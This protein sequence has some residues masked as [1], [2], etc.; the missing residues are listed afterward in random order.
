MS[1]LTSEER[2]RLPDEAFAYIDR[3][4]ERHLP[5]HDAAHVRNA[6]A[7]YPQTHFESKAAQER[8]RQKI[9]AAAQRFAIEV[10]EDAE[11]RQ[12]LD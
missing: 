9:L 1:E 5:I 2:N 12:P 8:A 6:I 7:R 4:G 11:V 10:S 3:A